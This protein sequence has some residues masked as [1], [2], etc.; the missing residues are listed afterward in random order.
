MITDPQTDPDSRGTGSGTTIVIADDHPIVRAGLRMVLEE[1]EDFHVVAEAGDVPQTLRKVLAYKP[2]VLLLDL[3]M[4]GGPSLSAIPALIKVSPGTA[5]VILTMQDD[6]GFARAAMRDGALGFVLKE[7]ADD[8]LVEAVRAASRGHK[9]LNPRLGA[10]IATEPDVPG[11]DLTRRER[12]VLK[13]ISLG[14]TNAEIGAT[15]Y[16]SVRTVESHRTHIQRKTGRTT[17]SELV[18]Y[19]REHGLVDR[20]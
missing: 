2:T 4:P 9:Y 18:A 14:Y 7:S 11:T 19:A 3:S 1:Q 15:L 16:L 12:E 13:L 10:L 5:I 20:G 6:P 17:R 8:E